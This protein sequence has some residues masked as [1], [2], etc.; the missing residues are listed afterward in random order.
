MLIN[1]ILLKRANDEQSSYTSK[2]KTTR[3]YRFI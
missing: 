2:D 1:A 3:S